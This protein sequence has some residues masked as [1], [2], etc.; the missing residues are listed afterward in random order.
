[1]LFNSIDYLLFL[2][3][4]F[5]LYWACRGVL[6]QNALT[7]VASYFFYGCWDW[8]F[9]GLIALTTLCSYASGLVAERWRYRSI[10]RIAVTASVVIN[11]GILGVF[12][13]YNFFA[14]SLADLLAL[15]G[16]HID[17]TTINV[18]LP[19][20]ISFYTFQAIGY[21]VDVYRGTVKAERD[22]VSFFA[23]IS[24]FPQLVAGPI[25]RARNLLP[26]FKKRRAFNYDIAADGMR[27]ILWGFFKKLVIADKCAGSVD[28][29]FGNYEQY[30]A[31]TLIFGMFLFILQ[32]YGDFSGYSDIA[33]GTAKLFGIK[34]TRNFNNP[35]FSV[36]MSELWQRWHITLMTWLR[37]YVYRSLGG[38]KRGRL[39]K[40][41]NV[42]VV[43]LLSGLWHGANWTYVVWGGL[44]AL[45]IT[46]RVVINKWGKNKSAMSRA[47][48]VARRIMVFVF[49]AIGGTIFRSATITDAANYL[50]RIFTLADGTSSINDLVI[51]LYIAVMLTT[52]WLMRNYNH[53][54]QIGGGVIAKRWIRR[55]I[56]FL[57]IMSIFWH[58][59]HASQF[60]YFQF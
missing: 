58:G 5:A 2:P 15:F 54:L 52:E 46:P 39:R 20:G 49:F 8:R 28:M 45:M 34:L 43:F 11:L 18:V 53:G 37:D 26:Q 1:M 47:E 12:K 41:R 27:Q 4:A 30:D 40:V 19:V 9:L 31:P 48:R 7:V 60:I 44:N 21:S 35:L 50:W 38:G 16:W 13:Y 42:W 17:W 33:I 6:W 14:G 29:Y 10:S 23:F 24:F 51:L 25:E 56:Y 55:A 57:L 59:Q 32:A 3:V 22:W 36:S